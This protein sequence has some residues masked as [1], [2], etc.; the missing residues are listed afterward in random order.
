MLTIKKKKN[1]LFKNEKADAS[2]M[3]VPYVNVNIGCV[4]IFKNS[5]EN[6]ML[7]RKM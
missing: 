2:I 5:M 3:Y 1:T 6:I 7:S 4:E